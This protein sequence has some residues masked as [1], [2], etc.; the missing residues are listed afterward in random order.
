ML[1]TNY[2]VWDKRQKA[3]C[4][5][6]LRPSNQNILEVCVT[7]SSYTSIIW[8][9]KGK[10]AIVDNED[11]ERLNQCKWSA[12]ASGYTY[13]AISK[14]SLGMHA[15]LMIN[16]NKLHIDH[17]NRNGLDNRKSNLR[18]C[19]SGQNQLNSKLRSHNTSGYKGVYWC[20]H[21]NAWASQLRVKGKIIYKRYFHS[22][23]EAALFYDQRAEELGD[24]YALTNK[25]LGLLP[26][27]ALQ[28]Q[29]G[30]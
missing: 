20:K 30:E 1:A 18:V 16:P 11:Y 23:L 3:Q 21:H 6:H 4:F 2:N 24:G 7:D 10:Y 8:L 29:K 5:P 15:M 17:I 26:A 13:Y 27:E 19:R 14:K 22:A 12:V 28:Q 25:M 9:S